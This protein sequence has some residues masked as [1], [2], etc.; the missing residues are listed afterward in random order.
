MRLL[1]VRAERHRDEEPGHLTPHALRQRNPRSAPRCC[2]TRRRRTDQP[3]PDPR[4]HSPTDQEGESQLAIATAALEHIA[5]QR[6]V[7]GVGAVWHRAFVVERIGP[8]RR[9]FFSWRS[10]ARSMLRG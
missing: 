6:L 8:Y 5:P 4:G 9:R 7:V 1:S 3:G 2:G 10:S